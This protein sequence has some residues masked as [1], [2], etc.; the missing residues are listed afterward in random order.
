MTICY[1]EFT[2]FNIYNE[3]HQIINM[4]FFLRFSKFLWTF[5]EITCLFFLYLFMEDV[6]VQAKTLRK[7]LSLTLKGLS[8][9]Y[10]F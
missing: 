6:F 10:T 3:I 9:I 8:R 2:V 5:L 1:M 7:V 4:I